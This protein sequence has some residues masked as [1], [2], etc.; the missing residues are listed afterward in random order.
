MRSVEGE[1]GLCAIA[2]FYQALYHTF[3][4]RLVNIQIKGFKKNLVRSQL[5]EES[6]QG[7]KSRLLEAI[8]E[9]E[10]GEQT[11]AQILERFH[12]RKSCKDGKYKLKILY[13]KKN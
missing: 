3:L 9:E 2:A 7:M 12:K 5:R 13:E 11:D 8:G 4:S 6:Y 10:G 1:G